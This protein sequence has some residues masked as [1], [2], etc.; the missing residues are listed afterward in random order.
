MQR[1]DKISR[2]AKLAKIRELVRKKK[3]QQ[4]KKNNKKLKTNNQGGMKR[5]TPQIFDESDIMKQEEEYD[6][7]DPNDPDFKHKLKYEDPFD[8]VIEKEIIEKNV[9]N[10]ASDDDDY[11][12]ID[13]ED[14]VKKSS[15]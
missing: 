14:I 9:D 13:A 1:E 6:N 4:K 11:E 2:N 12:S 15:F 7:V 10:E 8:D 5:E 3:K